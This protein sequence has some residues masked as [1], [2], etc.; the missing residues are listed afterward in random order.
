MTAQ[1]APDAAPVD[2]CR[3]VS[4]LQHKTKSEVFQSSLG[5]DWSGL[6]AIVV[7][8]G[9]DDFVSP[10]L[11]SHFLALCTQG[12]AIANVAFASLK[13]PGR[14]VVEPGILCF[15][16]AGQSAAL[17]MAGRSEC[18]HIFVNPGVMECVAEAAGH[19]LDVDRNLEGFAGR[20]HLAIQRTIRTIKLGLHKRSSAWADTIGLT[21]ATQLFHFASATARGGPD[22]IDLSGL[23]FGRAIDFIEANLTIDF[24]LE[25]MAQA[26]E[27]DIYRLTKGFAAEAGCGIEEY[28]LERRLGIVQALLRSSQ[29]TKMD[30]ETIARRVGFQD[31]AELDSSFR[32]V[33]GVSVENFRLGKLI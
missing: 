29:S 33:L 8:Q 30:L 17:E 10:P 28:R 1:D 11:Q 22:S 14:F 24:T 18:V 23:Q 7:E 5:S 20:H 9:D 19:E 21:L 2:D 31:A 6:Q 27:V 4:F 3:F 25:D 12:S 26:V 32:S 16:P 13:G 15:M